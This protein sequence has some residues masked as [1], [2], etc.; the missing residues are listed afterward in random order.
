MTE[1]IARP[2]A[3][4][5]PARLSWQGDQPFSRQFG[6]IYHAPDGIAEVERVFVEPQRL[7]ERF[8]RAHRVFTMG[9][10]GFGTA[11]NFAVVAQRYLERAPADARL[12]FITVEKHP[13]APREFATLSQRRSRA[14][15]IYKE[16]ARA[17]PPL[18][19][20]WHR[21]HFAAGRITLSVFFGDA[22][23]GF[24]DI[25]DRQR[26]P[27]DA[28]L[29][30]GFAPDRNPQLWQDSL[31]RTLAQ[32]SGEGSTVATFSA[33]G[34]VRRALAEAGFTMR[35]VDQRPHKRHT[36]AGVFAPARDAT[37][38]APR[39]VAVVGA[40]LAGAATA[41]QLADRGMAVTLFDAAPTPPN[42]MAATL[43]H[44]RLL[45]DGSV[46]ARLRCMAYLYSTHWYERV[47]PGSRPC[48]ALQ[49]PGPNMSHARL[50]LA[51]EAFTS[52]GDWV[53]RV[54]PVSASSLC[55]L[56]V[57]QHALFFPHARALDLGALGD[58]LIAHHSIEYR[59]DT[60][61]SAVSGGPDRAVVTANDG[62]FGLR[63]RRTVRW[64]RR[65][66]FRTGAIPRDAAGVGADRPD[67]ARAC[68]DDADGRRRLPDLD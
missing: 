54:D 14:L 18:L 36:L 30:D 49:F 22:A 1:P 37:Y 44:P 62:G 41:R 24:A 39:C 68:P 45:P 55:G 8:Q 50:E 9:E 2:G 67:R 27:V 15:P 53:A 4:I 40:G 5:I 33:V 7:S 65:Q 35:K 59:A 10:I 19:A 43:F 25:V 17:Y 64:R 28:W 42:R 12:H 6:D 26:L 32:L 3:P 16:L 58:A 47:A 46:G 21:R 20:G 13:I 11:L 63:S 23:S 48:G 31:W 66:R 38:A 61:C 51:A 60:S 52:T 56:P 34:A 57:R 29:L